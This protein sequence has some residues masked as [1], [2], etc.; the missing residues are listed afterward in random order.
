MKLR[1]DQRTLCPWGSEEGG[2][3]GDTTELMSMGVA[4]KEHH[5]ELRQWP[6]GNPEGRWVCHP[7][8][9]RSGG[10]TF[11]PSAPLCCNDR[12]NMLFPHTVA[13]LSKQWPRRNPRASAHPKGCVGM[14]KR[15]PVPNLS[16]SMAT[17]AMA[18]LQGSSGQSP[19]Q[20]LLL[21]S[22]LRTFRHS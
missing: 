6:L 21:V 22:C 20:W 5:A 19:G 4:G 17:N 9:S 3:P 8:D 18:C 10:G 16:V 14:S 7:S 2:D 1:R 13:V 12:L 11:L 15:L